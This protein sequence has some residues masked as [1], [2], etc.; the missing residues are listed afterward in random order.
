MDHTCKLFDLAGAGRVRH[1]FRGH[2]KY[3]YYLTI[4]GGF[5]QSCFILTLL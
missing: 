4:P 5:N 1:T 3:W 2:V